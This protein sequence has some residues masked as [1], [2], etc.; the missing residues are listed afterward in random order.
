[1]PVNNTIQIRKGS[2]TDWSNSNPILASGEPGY[3]TTNKI[4]KIG[5]GSSTWNSLSAV[6]GSS[7]T[8]LSDFDSA[9]NTN[10]IGYAISGSSTS[11]SVWTIKKT[12][13]NSAGSVV[14]S[15][16]ATNVKWDDRLTVTYS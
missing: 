3:D 15:T 9:S 1:M 7:K 5:D 11:S 6:G 13:Y 16:S 4:L 12:V 10:Y 14:S 2:A 8:I